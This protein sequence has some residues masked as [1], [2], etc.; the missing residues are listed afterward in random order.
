MRAEECIHG[1]KYSD[2]HDHQAQVAVN[3]IDGSKLWP[4]QCNGKPRNRDEQA[5]G[6]KSSVQLEPDAVSGQ[7]F[8]EEARNQSSNG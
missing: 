6:L 7:P 1:L 5:N 4:R 8:L 3:G 2:D